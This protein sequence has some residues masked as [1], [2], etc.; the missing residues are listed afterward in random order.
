MKTRISPDAACSA[1]LSAESLPMRGRSSTSV[2][3][4][5][6]RRLDGP[7]VGA[8]GGHDQLQQLGRVVGGEHVG[9]LVGDHLDLVVRRDDHRQ[10][11]LER[12][13]AAAGRGRSRPSS[14]ERQRVARVHPRHQRGGQRPAP[15]PPSSRR[16]PR[17]AARGQPEAR[18]R[19]TR[20]AR[21]RCAGSR[22]RSGRR[23]APPPAPRRAGR[24]GP[25]RRER[26]RH[27]PLS[28]SQSTPRKAIAP[29]SAGLGERL[30]V[31][32]VRAAL[33]RPAGRSR[34]RRSRSGSGPRSCPGPTPS[35]GWSRPHVQPGEVLAGAPA[36][37]GVVAEAGR[38]GARRRRTSAPTRCWQAAAGPR[39]SRARS[40]AHERHRERRAAARRGAAPITTATISSAI[41][42]ARDCV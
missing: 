39:A 26:A 32:V 41:S 13:R 12:R 25:A 14:D 5:R 9:H 22:R 31:E 15:R 18:G 4:A 30:Q 36:Q 11:Q 28:A 40:T 27:A 34:S 7:V 3:P 35:S 37:R 21:R 29:S 23:P 42:A 1:R 24:R 2:A 6:A 19:S 17:Q 38:G 8:V 10:R 20:S 16:P 33:L